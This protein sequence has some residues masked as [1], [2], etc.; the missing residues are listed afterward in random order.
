MPFCWFRGELCARADE[1]ELR[2]LAKR[3]RELL[4]LPKQVAMLAFGNATKAIA[5]CRGKRVGGKP[6]RGCPRIC[7]LFAQNGLPFCLL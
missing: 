5:G 1:E 2:R 3:L 4:P 6:L 7:Y